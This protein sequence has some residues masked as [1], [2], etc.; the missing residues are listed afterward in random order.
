MS[1]KSAIKCTHCGAEVVSTHRHDF[2]THSCEGMK[3]GDY[4]AA[5]GGNAYL[6]RIYGKREDWEEASETNDNSDSV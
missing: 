3:K 5:D 1:L 6:R 2:A 4:I